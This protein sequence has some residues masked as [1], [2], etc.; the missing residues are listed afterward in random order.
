MTQHSFHRGS[1]A[2]DFVG[3]VGRREF[4]PEE[5]LPTVSALGE[6]LRQAKLL[7]P[8]TRLTAAQF[9]FAIEVR[10]AA[11]KVLAAVADGLSLPSR[12]V[13]RLNAAAAALPPPQL[14]AKS[15]ERVFSRTNFNVAIACVAADA[16]AVASEERERLVRC[17]LEE[18]RGLLLSATAGE[19]RRWCSMEKCGNVA[20]VRAYRRR[21]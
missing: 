3:T 10:E 21:H 19:R 16:I 13:A 1:L 12:D 2:L 14:N 4:A 6:W 17:N 9:D 18:C 8:K 7:E 5:R 11:A 20:K 15:G